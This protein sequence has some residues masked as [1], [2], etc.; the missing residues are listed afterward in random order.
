MYDLTKDAANAIPFV[1]VDANNAEVPGLGAV[2]TVLLSR[3]GAGFGASAG[4]KAELA[5]GWYLYTAT[6]GECDTVGP[7]ALKITGAGCQQQN[8][9]CTVTAPIL[10]SQEVANAVTNLAPVGTPA[11]GSVGKHLDDLVDKVDVVDGVVDGIKVKTDTIGAGS[12]T[13]TSPVS[14]AG[15]VELYQGDDYHS[16]DSRALDFTNTAGTWPNL[17][18]AAVTFA[19]RAP[20]GTLFTKTGSVVTPMGV[21]V[22]RVELTA[23]E[24]ALLLE[25]PTA[26]DLRIRVTLA[27]GRKATIVRGDLE[28]VGDI[29]G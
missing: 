19:V 18:A 25:W 14:T 24:S 27:S 4:T 12:V 22:V 21:Q 9:V 7:L 8:L 1:L 11:T 26:S 3:N 10:T 28:T 29:I 16:S 5:G 6:A 15:D 17:T 2:F 13:V 23:A 20:D